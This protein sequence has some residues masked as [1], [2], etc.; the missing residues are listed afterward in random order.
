MVE[1]NATSLPKFES[2]QKLVD[3]FDSHD[4]G[5]YANELPEASF[6]VDIQQKHYLVSVNETRMQQLLTVARDQHVS[7]EL[8]LDNWL[9]EKL[10]NVS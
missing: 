3:F 9:K 7:V 4:M 5:D 6:E 10:M 2:E 8:L 1:S